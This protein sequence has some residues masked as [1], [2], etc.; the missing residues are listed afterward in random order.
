MV[1]ISSTH[2]A[3][4]AS[5]SSSVL[6]TSSVRSCPAEKAGPSARTTTTRTP[7]SRSNSRSAVVAACI[8]DVERA[9]RRRGS[10]S[11]R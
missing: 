9:L 11:V 8:V 2:V 4:T 6:S 10:V 1:V 3:K 7:S 5:S